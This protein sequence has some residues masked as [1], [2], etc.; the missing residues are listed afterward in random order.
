ML[1]RLC[2]T[3][4][5][6]FLLIATPVSAAT[7]EEKME[8]CKVGAT[9]QNLTGAKQQA[10]IKRCMGAGNYEPKARTDAMKANA[11]KPAAAKPAAAKPESEDPDE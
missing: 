9:A 3:A 1:G 7:Q 4:V 8:T 2:L 6:P 10:F 11:R 5:V